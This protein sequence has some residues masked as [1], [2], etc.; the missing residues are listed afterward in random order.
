MAPGVTFRVCNGALSDFQGFAY[1]CM[2]F[3]RCREDATRPETRAE[4][5]VGQASGRT[6]RVVLK[7]ITT[8]AM[9][10]NMF[11]GFSGLVGA[12]VIGCSLW[13]STQ[14]L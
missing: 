12:E 11:S 4:R 3:V 7:I 9:C 8:T 10:S 6:R 14:G 1:A 2:G 13:V 5:R